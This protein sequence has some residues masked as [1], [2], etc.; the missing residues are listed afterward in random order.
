[1]LRNFLKLEDWV[2]PLYYD[3]KTGYSR[4]SLGLWHKKNDV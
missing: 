2:L 3:G 4:Y 1:M